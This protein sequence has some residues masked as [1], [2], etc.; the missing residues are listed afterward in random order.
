MWASANLDRVHAEAEGK[1]V[2]ALSHATAA[3]FRN[4]PPEVQQFWQAKADEDTAVDKNQ[5]FEY[6][7]SC[8]L[9]DWRSDDSPQ[10]PRECHWTYKWPPLKPAGHGTP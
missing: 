1:G 6:A 5:C 2:G 4:K 9:T 8:M 7:L 10:K 3:L